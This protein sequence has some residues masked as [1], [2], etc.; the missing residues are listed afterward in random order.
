MKNAI[1]WFEIHASDLERGIKFYEGLLGIELVRMDMA[2]L[3]V[4]VFPADMENGGIGGHIQADPEVPP[5]PEGPVIYLNAEGRLDAALRRIDGL[6][7]LILLP[8]MSIG[9]SGWIALF[10]DSEGNR[11]G[12]HAMNP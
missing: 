9:D 2:G 11:V 7:G 4:A 1:N 8:K 12:L 6:G 5:A 3:P 10:R